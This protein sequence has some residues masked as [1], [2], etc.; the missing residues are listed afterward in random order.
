MAS[1]NIPKTLKRPNTLLFETT[2]EITEYNLVKLLLEHCQNITLQ[3][4]FKLE[5]GRNA[6]ND[7]NDYIVTTSSRQG[8]EKLL[9][10]FQNGVVNGV[11]AKLVETGTTTFIE[12][13][14]I[15]LEILASTIV[16]KLAPYVEI[17]QP[18]RMK[19]KSPMATLEN[20]VRRAKV[21]K[22]LRP[23]PP[24]INLHGISYRLHYIAPEAERYCWRCWEKGHNTRDCTN[25]KRCR[26]CYQ[27]GHEPGDCYA[28]PANRSTRVRLPPEQQGKAETTAQTADCQ[29]EGE[30]PHANV[31]E[32]EKLLDEEISLFNHRSTPVQGDNRVPS[33]AGGAWGVATPVVTPENRGITQITNMGHQNLTPLSKSPKKKTRESLGK[34]PERRASNEKP[35]SVSTPGESDP[36]CSTPTHIELDITSRRS[37]STEKKGAHV[38]PGTLRP[39]SLLSKKLSQQMQSRSP[40]LKR[41]TPS[42]FKGVSPDGKVNNNSQ[43]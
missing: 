43:T 15:P 13:R 5:R 3:G 2:P 8:C 19:H 33:P 32:L 27:P 18:D 35:N 6:N 20:G 31:S 34:S 7:S 38:K 40:S 23:L 11:K 30:T 14:E 17:E 41:S 28:N 1:A 9:Q 29:Q 42:D 26:H 16:Y 12:L 25:D 36:R 39:V 4:L 10:T 24:Y 22:I 21:L 37:R